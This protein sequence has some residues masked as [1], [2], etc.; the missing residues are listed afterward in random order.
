MVEEPE[1]NPYVRDPDLSFRDVGELS[2]EEAGTQVERLRE[3]IDYHDYR[4]YGRN[5]PVVA[6]ETYDALF[7]RLRSLEETFDL[8]DENSPTQRVG[9]EPLESLPTR[10]HVTP[11]RSLASS[12]D[13]T[14]VRAFADLYDLEPD[15]L[16]GLEALGEA[17]AAALHDEI[18]S[19][20]CSSAYSTTTSFAS[21]NSR[22]VSTRRSCSAATDRASSKTS[23]ARSRALSYHSC[24]YS[25]VTDPGGAPSPNF[26]R[27]RSTMFGPEPMGSMTWSTTTSASG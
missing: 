2:A 25:G 21:P 13:E 11:M 20:P 18:R 12:T 22:T 17:S 5:D 6:D 1:D 16:A 19:T 7:E 3:A 4:Y 9:G 10:E 15:E 26:G 27:I 24:Q 23:S 8:V 14:D